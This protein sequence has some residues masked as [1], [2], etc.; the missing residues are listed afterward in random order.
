[1]PGAPVKR[2]ATYE[3]LLQVP[4][5]LVA[6]IVDGDLVTSPRPSARHALATSALSAEIGGAFGRGGRGGPG[7]WIIL[8]E[9]ELHV[10][11]QVLVP[12]LAGWRHARMP[13][14]PDVAF[15]DL[16]PDWLCEVLSPSTAALD[17]TRKMHH[18]ARAGVKHVWLLDP[19]HRAG[20]GGA[21]SEVAVRARRSQSSATSETLSTQTTVPLDGPETTLKAKPPCG[22]A[23]VGVKVCVKVAGW[24]PGTSA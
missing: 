10:V 15:L 14:V 22:S 20:H 21:L 11:G 13:E 5:S 8:Y 12:D 2:P 23:T 24:L 6:E 3:D 18:Y 7:G 4:E 16:A 1:M 9:P 17:R 19:G